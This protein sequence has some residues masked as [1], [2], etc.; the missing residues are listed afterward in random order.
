MKKVNQYKLCG[1]VAAGIII[2]VLL[3]YWML[4]SN[5]PHPI[6]ASIPLVQTERVQSDVDDPSYSYSGDVRGRYESKLAFQ[7]GGKIIRRNVDLGSV[8]GSGSVL[9]QIDPVDVRQGVDAQKAQVNAAESQYRLARDNYYRFKEVY[10]NNH[11]SKAE[12]QNYQNAYTAAGSLLRQAQAQYQEGMNQLQYCN[13][14]AG[15]AGVVAAV[16]AEVG[17]VVAPGQPVITLVRGKELEIEMNLPENRMREIKL[18]DKVEV[19]FWAL[20]DVIVMGRV[21]EIAPMADPL[22][23]TFRVR[24]SLLNPPRPIKLGMTATVTMKPSETG[25][26]CIP[27]AA[28]YQTEDTAAVWTVTNHFVHLRRIKVGEFSGTKIKVLEGLQPGEVIVTAGVHKLQ[29][30]VKVLTIAEGDEAE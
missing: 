14:Y 23:R 21:R 24:V 12:F 25:A 18:Q 1:V 27:L 15:S 11:M 3:T 9:M 10:D 17:Q 28:I 6:T 16:N 7:V 19:T 20:P 26:I 22:T 8:V 5:S 13:L 30:G 29:E 4:K 2:I